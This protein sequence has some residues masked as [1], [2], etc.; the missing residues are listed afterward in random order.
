VVNQ[1]VSLPHNPEV[2]VLIADSQHDHSETSPLLVS[3]N[4]PHHFDTS[5]EPPMN[6]IMWFQAPG[7]LLSLG[8]LG[9]AIYQATQSYSQY[10]EWHNCTPKGTALCVFERSFSFYF[11]IQLVGA[12]IQSL[13][14]AHGTFAFLFRS[15][16]GL[17][18]YGGAST[19]TIVW[20]AIQTIS[21]IVFSQLQS[22]SDASFPITTILGV[23]IGWVPIITNILAVNLRFHL[24]T[25]NLLTEF[26]FLDGCLCEPTTPDY[27]HCTPHALIPR[28]T[29]CC[30]KI[31]RCTKCGREWKRT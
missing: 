12:I 29:G 4:S 21:F 7:F 11:F 27:S 5:V 22:K 23:V 17:E 24:L 6:T 14:S 16:K 28:T 20:Q 31:Y 25:W 3:I 19:A 1:L 2:I 10:D 18:I 30:Q 9:F 13:N 15:A 26:T 8:V